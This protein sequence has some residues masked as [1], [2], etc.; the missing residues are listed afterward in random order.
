MCLLP[1]LYKKL[2]N[3]IW[4]SVFVFMIPNF[5]QATPLEVQQIADGVFVH[6]GVHEDLDEGYHGDICNIGFIIGE[7]A[8][9]VIDTG[10]SMH[11]GQRLLETIRNVSKLPILYVINTHVHPDHIFGNAAFVDKDT[12]FIGHERL[13]EA[14]EKRQDS[15]MR[16]NQQW[17]KDDF[18]GSRIVKPDIAVKGQ[19][20]IDLGG[21]ILSLQG[22]PTAHTNSDLTVFDEKTATLWTGDLL[23]IERTPSI[24]GDIKGWIKV[25]ETLLKSSAKQAVSGHGILKPQQTWQQAMQLQQEYL[26]TLLKDVRASISKNLPMEKAMDSAASSQKD[27]W[28]L[29]DIINRRNVNNIYPTLEWE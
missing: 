14:M 5:L 9:A 18:A 13:A 29:F 11:V 7:Q 25:N 20:R 17:L 23:F 4:L 24:D 19:M 28:Q 6:R 15:Y 1:Q 21:R 16:I 2:Q 8:I 26:T 10:G 22:Y 27:R 12:K 3:Q